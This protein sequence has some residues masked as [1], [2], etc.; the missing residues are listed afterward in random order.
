M[1]AKHCGDAAMPVAASDLRAHGALL[2]V[3][4]RPR[5]VDDDRL[6]A[7]RHQALF[8]EHLEDAS[9]HFARAADQAAQLLPRH[10][11][12]HAVRVSHGVRLVAEIHDGVR[13]A[14]RDVDKSEV[15]EFAIVLR[16]CFGL[17]GT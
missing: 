11:D 4:V 9:R 1:P 16:C 12:L 7:G 10:L 13:N 6:A 3:S 15:A 5:A 17:V 14:A 2:Q 8:L